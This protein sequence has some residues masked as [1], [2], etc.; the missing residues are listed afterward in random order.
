MR[1]GTA[2][3]PD[4]LLTSHKPMDF[5]SV[6]RKATEVTKHPDLITNQ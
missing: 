6:I 5:I 2:V 1:L 4:T 3:R